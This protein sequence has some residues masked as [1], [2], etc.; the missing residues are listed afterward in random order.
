MIT[1][2]PK[3]GL[4]KF[5]LEDGQDAEF[6]GVVKV[7]GETV[8]GVGRKGSRQWEVCHVGQVVSFDCEFKKH[9]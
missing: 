8:Y 4:V 1:E 2:E 5:L 3:L 9:R 7:S 6:Y